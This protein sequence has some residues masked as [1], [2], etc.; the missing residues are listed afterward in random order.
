MNKNSCALA[1]WTKR[2][3]GSWHCCEFQKQGLFSQ[4]WLKGCWFRA[5]VVH[6]IIENHW[7]CEEVF[8]V[9][10][11]ESHPNTSL[12]NSLRY[13]N[14]AAS[15]FSHSNGTTNPKVSPKKFNTYFISQSKKQIPPSPRGFP[16]KTQG[17]TDIDTHRRTHKK[18]Q[19]K[20]AYILQTS[21]KYVNIQNQ[22]ISDTLDL[23][24]MPCAR[25]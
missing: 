22:S 14:K 1:G 20:Q 6:F 4:A 15:P 5:L 8:L 2:Q 25:I 9:T 24:S 12:P 19:R 13:G 11:T 10:S 21:G 23:P 16:I 3:Q 7:R 18:R 17:S